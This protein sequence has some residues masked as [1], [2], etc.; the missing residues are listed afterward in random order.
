V[1]GSNEGFVRVYRSTNVGW[2]MARVPSSGMRNSENC[3]DFHSGSFRAVADHGGDWTHAVHPGAP[4]NTCYLGGDPTL[5]DGFTPTDARGAWEP[6]PG[7]SPP[8]LSGQP[9]AGYLFPITRELNPDFKGVIHV[10]GAVAISGM[11]RGRVTVSATGNIWVT[12]DLKYTVEPA[13]N[14]CHDILGMF[15]GNNVIIANNTL[16]TPVQ[17]QPGLAWRRYDPNI[18][19]EGLEVHGIVLALNQ[20]TVED[21]LNAPANQVQCGNQSWGRGCLFLRGGIIQRTRGAVGALYAGGLGTGFLK[22]YSWDAC[23]QSQPPPYFPTTGVFFAGQTY[24][25]DPVGFD[26]DDFFAMLAF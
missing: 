14:T 20:F 8:I 22:R 1:N 7:I 6:W 24:Q 25:V 16:N 11:V 21:F 13:T 5:S 12:D 19:P 10:D 3:G 15:A 9:D 26:I 2:L 23:G 4:Q 18:T 17:P